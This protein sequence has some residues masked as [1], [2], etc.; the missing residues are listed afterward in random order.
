MKP[1]LTLALIAGALMV[2]SPGQAGMV[3]SKSQC[4]ASCGC[5]QH[6]LRLDHQ[7]RQVQSLS[8]PPDQ[9]VP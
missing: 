8:N 2:T 1:F 3:A 4:L 5:D 9:T 6:L 7:A